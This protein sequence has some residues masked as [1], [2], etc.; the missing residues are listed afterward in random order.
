[1]STQ[2]ASERVVLSECVLIHH[3]GL[4]LTL[5]LEKL[6]DDELAQCMQHIEEQN[7]K[8]KK[9]RLVSHPI[10]YCFVHVNR[11]GS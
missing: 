1:M 8:I 9:R 3:V 5:L 2:N 11:D 4:S 7:E 10:A 6:T